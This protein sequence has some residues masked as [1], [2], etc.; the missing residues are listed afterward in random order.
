MRGN[1]A[2]TPYPNAYADTPHSQFVDL[3]RWG[4]AT[5]MNI[6]IPEFTGTISRESL[7]FITNH[8]AL[9]FRR[10]I[11]AEVEKA[12]TVCDPASRMVGALVERDE[13]L[14]DGINEAL[15]KIASR[16]EKRFDEFTDLYVHMLKKKLGYRT[17]K[18]GE[19]MEKELLKTPL[20]PDPVTGSYF[21]ANQGNKTPENQTSEFH[22]PDAGKTPKVDGGIQDLASATMKEIQAR[23]E[24]FM[25]YADTLDVSRINDEEEEEEEGSAQA[26]RMQLHDTS[27]KSNWDQSLADTTIKDVKDA[28]AETTNEANNNDTKPKANPEKQS[29]PAEVEQDEKSNTGLTAGPVEA[30][31]GG[32]EGSSDS[33]GLPPGIND[34]P[35]ATEEE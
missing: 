26:L 31:D 22:T 10:L 14:C 15:D 11:P 1:E 4:M 35:G 8:I 6:E 33:S 25:N 29:E 3:N 9:Q 17:G 23:H 5:Q 7:V 16:N 18:M 21:G 30:N 27:V 24:S 32:E 12:L 34:I 13:A 19:D 20:K 2:R 28:E